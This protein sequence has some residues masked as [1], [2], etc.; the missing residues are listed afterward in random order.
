LRDIGVARIAQEVEWL[1][2][3][4]SHGLQERGYTVHSPHGRHHRGGILNFSPGPDSVCRSLEDIDARLQK[5]GVSYARRA[6]G[7]RLSPHAFNTKEE[8]DRVLATLV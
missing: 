1:T 7:V 4:L 2:R 3:Y 6:P 8:L 5:I